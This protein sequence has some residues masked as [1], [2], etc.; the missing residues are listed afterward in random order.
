MHSSIYKWFMYI[1][2]GAYFYVNLSYNLH[3][4]PS[5]FYLQTFFRA[6]EW[7]NFAVILPHFCDTENGT[8]NVK[9]KFNLPCSEIKHISYLLLV[10]P[11]GLKTKGLATRNVPKLRLYDAATRIIFLQRGRVH[12]FSSCLR[13]WST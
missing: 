2:I 3:N 11:F 5:L 1:S 10:G 8:K 4:Y 13:L 9:I 6:K 12:K 7:I